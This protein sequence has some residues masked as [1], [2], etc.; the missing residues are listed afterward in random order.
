MKQEIISSLAEIAKAESEVFL[1]GGLTQKDIFARTG[2]FL[3]ERRRMADMSIGIPTSSICIRTHSLYSSF[4]AHTHDFI[5]LMYVCRGSITHIIGNKTIELSKGDIILLGKSTKHAIL[6]TTEEDI[7]VNIIISTD[8]FDSLLSEL[9]KSS[10]L[11]EK[12]FERMLGDDEL[13]YCV[14][15]T[16]GIDHI[17]N[18]M[19]NL[20]RS[21]ITNTMTDIFIMQTSLTLL[22][23]YLALTPDLLSDFSDMDTYAEQTK[24]KIIN[25]IHTSYKTASLSEAA[26]MLGLS[27]AHL[28][29]WIKANFG[30][31]FKDLLCD[32]RF[33]VAKDLLLR[34]E[35]SISDI[36]V[37][38]GYENSS[39]FHKQFLKR[40]G[41]T[42]NNFRKAYSQ[43]K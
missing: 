31:G 12:T 37:N 26:E 35:L 7:G 30:W 32:K 27:S 17:T 41:M 43:I 38:V 9:R 18:L 33:E 42:P 22:F 29:R 34:T 11:P 23:S 6:A 4:P 1:S 39:Y 10:A 19:E 3:I 5:E 24:R 36:I 15:K 2:R 21:L 28:S 16:E 25:Y 8:Y 13:Q 40:F 14:F 20:S